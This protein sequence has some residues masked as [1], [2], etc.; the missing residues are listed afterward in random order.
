M[1]IRLALAARSSRS[2]LELSD[3][4]EPPCKKRRLSPIQAS[5]TASETSS[6]IPQTG[7]A[8]TNKT[9][10]TCLNS[11]HTSQRG[12]KVFVHSARIRS[13]ITLIVWMKRR[14]SFLQTHVSGARSS[15]RPVALLSQLSS[16]VSLGHCSIRAQFSRVCKPRILRL[17][18]LQ[19]RTCRG[20]RPDSIWGSVDWP[21]GDDIFSFPEDTIS[22][23]R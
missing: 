22:L 20:R 2:P 21:G 1:A 4:R 13:V 3:R 18:L 17:C 23:H 5:F 6:Y 15:L 10:Q 9:A 19:E 8:R 12:K 16:G 14:P 7:E 11:S